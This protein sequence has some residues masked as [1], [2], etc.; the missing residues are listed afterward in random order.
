M[1]SENIAQYDNVL[2]WL[3]KCG[4]PTPP[5][6]DYSGEDDVKMAGMNMS[7]PHKRGFD[8]LGLDPDRTPTRNEPNPNKRT[9]NGASKSQRSQSDASS[10]TSGYTTGSVRQQ[11]VNI[12]FGD[13]SVEAPRDLLSG[14]AGLPPTLKQFL[15]DL[16][17]ETAYNL[18]PESHR[19]ALRDYDIPDPCFKTADATNAKSEANALPPPDVLDVLELYRQAGQCYTRDAPEHTWNVNVHGPVLKLALHGSF[20]SQERLVDY[21]PMSVS[22]L[23]PCLGNPT[24]LYT[25][26]SHSPVVLMPLLF[27][28]TSLRE[29]RLRS[30]TFA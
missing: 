17:K 22:D 16:N 29:P 26:R 8:A 23:P 3:Q 14:A 15:K 25:N 2:A 9:K 24:E 1:A 12:G 20:R 21:W 7:T 4:Y 30:L 27:P 10:V 28:S 6:S 5:P 13:M 11:M 18:V 19:H